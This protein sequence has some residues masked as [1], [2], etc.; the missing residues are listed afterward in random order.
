MKN[1]KVREGLKKVEKLAKK[2]GRPELEP[3]FDVDLYFLCECSDE[4]CGQRLKINLQDY[5]KIHKSRKR[6]VIARGHEVDNI[7]DIINKSKN[8]QVVKKYKAPSENL[9]MLNKTDV[10][11]K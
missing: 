2:E 3:D 8:Y 7:E 1:E 9:V 4:N 6:F 11:N 5:T 10:N